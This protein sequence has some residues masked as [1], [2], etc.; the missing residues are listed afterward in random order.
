MSLSASARTRLR[1]LVERKLL[2]EEKGV[3]SEIRGLLA[4]FSQTELDELITTVKV[5]LDL[6]TARIRRDR[7]ELLS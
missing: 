7:P 5:L 1:N 2:R 4:S 3:G 6:V